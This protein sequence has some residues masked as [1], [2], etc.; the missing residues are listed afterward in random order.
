MCPG[1]FRGT[2]ILEGVYST[3]GHLIESERNK[4]NSLG[5][6][7]RCDNEGETTAL[8]NLGVVEGKGYSVLSV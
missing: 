2:V 5:G 8:P 4:L 6:V 3:I 1:T 7:L